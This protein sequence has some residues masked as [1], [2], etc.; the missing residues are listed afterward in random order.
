EVGGGRGGAVRGEDGVC[1]LEEGVFPAVEAFV[2]RAAEGAE[3]IG[4]F[5][6][7]PI[8]RSPRGFRILCRQRS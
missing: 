8:M 5:H 4:G 1:E 6:D 7:V 2:E 3:S